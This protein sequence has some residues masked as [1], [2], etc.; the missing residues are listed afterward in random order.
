MLTH[1]VKWPFLNYSVW[2]QKL[3]SKWP[4][5]CWMYC[6]KEVIWD[7]ESIFPWGNSRYLH[8][9]CAFKMFYSTATF[10]KILSRSNV[11]ILYPTNLSQWGMKRNF[12]GGESNI[13]HKWSHTS[14]SAIRIVVFSFEC[15]FNRKPSLVTLQLQMSIWETLVYFYF[16][17]TKWLRL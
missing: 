6:N 14:R 17:N 2:W 1:K 10:S 13:Q 9:H 12:P 8:S 16:L 3:V 15:S 11:T 7:L 4:D 5:L